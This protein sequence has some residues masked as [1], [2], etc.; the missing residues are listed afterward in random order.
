MRKYFLTIIFYLLFLYPSPAQI[1]ND[2]SAFFKSIKSIVTSETNGKKIVFRLDTLSSSLFPFKNDTEKI[3]NRVRE[4]F[5]RDIDFGFRHV[6]IKFGDNFNDIQLNLICFNDTIFLYSINSLKFK[7]M[8]YFDLDQNKISEF[9]K[10]R[11]NLYSSSISIKQLISEISLK[12]QYAFYCG[13]KMSKTEMG[14]K[15]EEL[16]EDENVEVLNDMLKSISCEIQAFGIAGFEMLA[17]LNYSIENDT[18]KLIN[19]I[20]KRNSELVVCYGC[21]PGLIDRIYPEHQKAN[22]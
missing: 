16:V 5:D 12:E 8:N 14:V 6:R 9:I 1:K 2:T 11:N 13:A 18:Q 22:R 21:F 20:K 17:K 15:I 10:Q 4:E 3:M 7:S 19:Y